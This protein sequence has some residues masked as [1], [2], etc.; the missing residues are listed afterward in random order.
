M[1]IRN[2]Y[3]RQTPDRQKVLVLFLYFSVIFGVFWILFGSKEV[4]KEQSQVT[5][6]SIKF[7]KNFPKMYKTLQKIQIDDTL[8][9]KYKLLP[10][11]F[12]KIMWAKF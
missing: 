8:L 4:S 1:P 12:R 9:I 11:D 6:F 7:I 2:L 5:F 10:P 3:D